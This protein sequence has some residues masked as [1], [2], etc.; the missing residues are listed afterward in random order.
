MF[1]SIYMKLFVTY[2]SLF[3]TIILVISFFMISIVY[4]EFTLQAESNL[5]NAGIRTNALMERYYNNEITRVELNSWIN[6]MSYISNIKI[7]VLNP[8]TSRLSVGDSEGNVEL[9]QQIISDITE[10]M[11]GNTVKRMNPIKLSS[12]DEIVYVGMPLEYN[13]Q[14]SGVILLFTPMTE[15]NN[16]S[17]EVL[18]TMLIIITIAVLLSA[19][20]ILRSSIRISEP[21]VEISNYAIDLGRGRD[22]PDIN[23]TSK[24]EIGRLARSFNI[25]KREISVAEQM[26][27]D[28]VANVSHEL[29]T[30]LTSIIG[31]LKG[32]LDGII[33]PEDEKK[34]LQIAYDEANRLKDLTKEIV[35][36]AKYESGSTKL[37]KEKFCLNDLGKD[38]KLELEGMIKEKGLRLQLEEKVKNINLFADK[39]RIRQ[40]LI[41]TINNSFKF[42]EKG[43]IKLILNKKDKNAI[44]Q[45]I[46]TGIGIQKD[47]IS[48]LFN[49][50]YTANE[51]G[52]ATN[53]AGLGLN[54]VKNI[55]D[56]H[57]GDVNIES[58]IGK[59]TKITVRIPTNLEE[60]SVNAK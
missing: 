17:K 6:A 41:N 58:E 32:I 18:H 36:V 31:F 49:K 59:G 42:T 10:I 46:D 29:R 24:D 35:E 50:F 27:R 33:K 30:P 7:Y 44:I 34:Y 13:G 3:L 1:K 4:R 2:L 15:L 22:V 5:E 21:I 8:D 9:N 45:I 23:I 40:V 53:G 55:V 47:K 16:I 43:Y 26:R 37:N 25:M 39:D 60:M 48:Y 20:T 54:I 11:N 12:E 56:M 51:Y 19:F 38:V 52:N 14:I 28:I 57:G